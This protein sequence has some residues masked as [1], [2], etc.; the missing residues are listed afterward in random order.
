MAE[1]GDRWQNS[2]EL[3]FI[4]E[5]VEP[6]LA[7]VVATVLANETYD[8]AKVAGWIDSICEKSIET[9]AQLHKP[10]KYIGQTLRFA[11][12]GHARAHS[13]L[14]HHPEER[15]RHPHGPRLLLGRRQRQQRASR[16]SP[17]QQARSPRQS[18]VRT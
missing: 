7:N 17:S 13:E 8:D 2:E 12:S 1:D 18:N 5:Q 3:A 10:F 6:L 11:S 16:I 14:R 9:L 4:P 15:R